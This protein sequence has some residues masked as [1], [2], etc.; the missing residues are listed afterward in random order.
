MGLLLHWGGG[1]FRDHTLKLLAMVI[2]D[3]TPENANVFLWF[4]LNNYHQPTLE[5]QREAFDFFATP[6]VK[7]RGIM[8]DML[9]ASHPQHPSW[10][11]LLYAVLTIG[12]K[13]NVEE[14]NLDCW[15]RFKTFLWPDP[16]M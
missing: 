14:M 4:I 1:S 3:P 9:D 12:Y 11:F 16:K 15:P 6:R 13:V 10:V 5:Q 8:V 2:H 7:Q